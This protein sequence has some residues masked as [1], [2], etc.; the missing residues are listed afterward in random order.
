MEWKLS[1]FDVAGYKDQPVPNTFI[2]QPHPARHLGIILPGYRYPVEMPPLHYAGRVLLEGGADLL[3]VEYAY[4]RTDFMKLA[5]IEQ[6]RWMSEDV[7]AACRAALSRGSYEKIA[8][9]GKSM[10]TIAMGQLLAD[11]AFQR[12]ACIWLTPLLTVE[13]LRLR[14][15]KLHPPSLFVIGTADR[16]YKPEILKHLE[17]VTGGRSLVM[18]GVNHA[19]EIPGDIPESLAVLDRIVEGLQEFLQEDATS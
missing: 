5:E 4:Y 14:I 6:D 7:F 17:H 10:G 11:E 8:L 1:S 12:A 15:E 3:R 13:R 18:E 16:F 9:V 2:A 19:L